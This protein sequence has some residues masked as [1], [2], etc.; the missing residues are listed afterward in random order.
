MRIIGDTILVSS[1]NK[2]YSKNFHKK[3]I[4]YIGNPK[5]EN[6][7]LKNFVKFNKRNKN[8]SVLFAYNAHRGLDEKLKKKLEKQLFSIMEIL[9]SFKNLKINFRI[10]PVKNDP[11]YLSILKKFSK[12]NINISE[13][14]L[15]E[16]GN[17]SDLV[18]APNGSGAILD[19]IVCKRPT[20]ELWDPTS[21]LT[22]KLNKNFTNNVLIKNEIEFEKFFKIGLSQPGN[23]IWK[24]QYKNFKTFFK[25][26]TISPK[27]IETKF[28]QIAKR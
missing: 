3:K 17:K 8:K 2:K 12:K 10:H 6:W 11:Y 18:I 24:K 16:L 5:Y 22:R 23:I 15:I 9:T 20:L 25:V 21:F 4:V 13:E 14:H 27:E 28:K 7:W 19:G 26:K 1:L